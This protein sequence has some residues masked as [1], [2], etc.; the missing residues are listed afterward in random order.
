[1]DTPGFSAFDTEQMDLVYK[2]KLQEYFVEFLP[3]IGNCRF[4]DC[5]HLNEPG[6]AILAAVEA[7]K[8][9]RSRYASYRRLYESAAKIKLW[10]LEK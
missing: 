2:E 9:P 1:M 8:I 6:C 7:G 10:E 4:D 5:A 3:Y